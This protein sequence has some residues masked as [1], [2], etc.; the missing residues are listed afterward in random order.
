MHTEFI[1]TLNTQA[2]ASHISA[3]GKSVTFVL[4]VFSLKISP[5][6][7]GHLKSPSTH[8]CWAKYLNGDGFLAGTKAPS[9]PDISTALLI[10]CS[11]GSGIWFELWDNL[12]FPFLVALVNNLN[13][14]SELTKNNIFSKILVSWKIINTG[15]ESHEM[16]CSILLSI[17]LIEMG[18][19]FTQAKEEWIFVTELT[20]DF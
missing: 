14:C 1:P 11:H 5:P 17:I 18:F 15:S 12:N 2:Q 16:L 19:Q 7:H 6:S 3:T 10:Y 8:S 13:M 4:Q 9:S 20:V